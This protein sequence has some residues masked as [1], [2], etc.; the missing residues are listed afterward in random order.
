MSYALRKKTLTTRRNTSTNRREASKKGYVLTSAMIHK[1]PQRD[2]QTGSDGP[3]IRLAEQH[4][5]RWIA[6]ICLDRFSYV[7]ISYIYHIG[8]SYIYV[9][10]NSATYGQRK[11][12]TSKSTCERICTCLRT[13]TETHS[14]IRRETHTKGHVHRSTM[15]H[16]MPSTVA[17]SR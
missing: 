7:D 4:K 17:I 10:V 3:Q 5:H 9:Y 11:H 13:R 2:P 1:L 15:M 14:R 8:S 12:H 6:R 16:K